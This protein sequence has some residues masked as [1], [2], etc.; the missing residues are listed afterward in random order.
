MAVFLTVMEGSDAQ[1]AT[2]LL[3]TRDRQLIAMVSRELGKRLLLHLAPSDQNK[4][5]LASP[6]K[7]GP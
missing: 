5:T 3:V 4:P 2:P 6:Q 7:D 1:S